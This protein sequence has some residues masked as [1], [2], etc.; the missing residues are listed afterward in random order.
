MMVF[1]VLVFAVV[2][3]FLSFLVGRAGETDKGKAATCITIIAWG[4]LIFGLYIG[5][6]AR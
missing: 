4:S 6:V 5:R 2:T 3:V 1:S